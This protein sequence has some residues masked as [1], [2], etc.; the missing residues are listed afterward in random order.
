MV[1]IELFRNTPG[2]AQFDTQLCTTLQSK[3]QDWLD[4]AQDWLKFKVGKKSLELSR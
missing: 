2:A 4:G 1:D 3:S